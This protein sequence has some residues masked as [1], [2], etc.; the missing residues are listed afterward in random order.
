MKQVSWLL[1]VLSA[2]IVLMFLV[3]LFGGQAPTVA[4]RKQ[5]ESVET[6]ASDNV[7]PTRPSESTARAQSAPDR[8]FRRDIPAAPATT[9]QPLPPVSMPLA[10]SWSL[11]KARADKGDAPAACRLAME[12]QRCRHVTHNRELILAGK[13]PAASMRRRSAAPETPA[14]RQARVAHC[15]GVDPR[16]FAEQIG[17]TRQAALAGNLPAIE[18]YVGAMA[19]SLDPYAASFYLEDYA[20]EAP[21]LAQA[22]IQAGSMPMVFEMQVSLGEMAGDTMLSRAMGEIHDAD[23]A[24]AMSLVLNRAKA[25]QPSARAPTPAMGPAAQTDADPNFERRLTDWASDRFR[26]WFGGQQRQFDFGGFGMHGERRDGQDP[27][28]T[29]SGNYIGD[30]MNAPAIDWPKR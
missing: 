17:L 18:S 20:R 4:Q 8:A 15:A 29:C 9:W 16:W 11:L 2:A 12:L 26:D 1:L 21:R 6:S 5:S 28:A 25:P 14:S 24:R 30:P 7:V 3:G 13:D 22:A 10:A 19:L 27:N 23:R